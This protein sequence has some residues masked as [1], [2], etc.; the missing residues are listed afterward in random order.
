M[1]IYYKFLP[2]FLTQLNYESNNLYKYSYLYNGGNYAAVIT[3]F[4]FKFYCMYS[5]KII[6]SLTP[7]QKQNIKNYAKLYGLTVTQLIR[8]SINTFL[9]ETE[10]LKKQKKTSNEQL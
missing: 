2:I 7:D 3:N 5:E 8:S 1:I 6:I 9:T 10:Y 4:Y